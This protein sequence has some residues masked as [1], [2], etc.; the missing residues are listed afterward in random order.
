MSDPDRLEL[1]RTLLFVPGSDRDKLGKAARFG[2]DA[3]VIDLEDAVAKENK[4]RARD[5]ARGAVPTYGDGPVVMVR[6]NGRLS[7]RMV[8]DIAGVVVRGLDAVMVPKVEDHRDLAMA[9]SALEDAERAAGME[10]GAVRLIPLIETARGIAHCEDLADQ[11]PSRTLTLAF[12]SGD[13]TT[14]MGV[15]P[16]ADG[17]E[18]AYARGRLVV[19]ARA[20]G[21]ARPIDGP[22]LDLLDID[23]LE[24]DCARS[25]Q[26]GYQ[27]R[28]IVYPPQVAPAQR[29]YS[30][31][32]EEALAHAR[33][34]VT[35]FEEAEARGVASIRVDERFVDYPIYRLARERLRLHEAHQRRAE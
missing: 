5:L 28:I 15:E 12:G 11:A 19:A 13:F 18:L 8:D 33:R 20:A 6:V 4:A 26:L 1:L 29:V 30:A 27:G 14:E 31:M 17:S 25:R 23:G 3:I 21:L 22:H 10:P 9:H 2:S 7:G 24:R 16:S 35:A 32:S 34:V